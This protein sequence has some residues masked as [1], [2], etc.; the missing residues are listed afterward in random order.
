MRHTFL[1]HLEFGGDLR[2]KA[3]ELKAVELSNRQRISTQIQEFA[4]QQDMHTFVY[5]EDD[6]GQYAFFARPDLVDERTDRY[7]VGA[8]REVLRVWLEHHP[9]ILSF[10]LGA[11]S[12][13]AMITPKAVDDGLQAGFISKEVVFE[14]SPNLDF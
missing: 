9:R 13:L 2:G 1:L 11:I 4:S 14:Q 8:L 5:S 12:D 6:V 10:E 7:E 3:V